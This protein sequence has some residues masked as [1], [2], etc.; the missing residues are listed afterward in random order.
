MAGLDRGPALGLIVK[1]GSIQPGC[2]SVT[3]EPAALARHLGLLPHHINHDALELTGAFTL[4]RRGV[5]ARLVF[6][7]TSS[8][9]DRT[10][11]KNIARGWAWF[12]EVKTGITMQTIADREGMTQ[13][14]IAHLVDLAFLAPDIVQAIVEGRQ[15]ATLTADGLIK[16]RHRMIWDDQRAWLASI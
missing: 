16:A 3:L 7:D 4:R 11:L 5:E 8:G 13:R 1:G 6:D 14:R 10:L 2:L 9:V 12:E 15:P